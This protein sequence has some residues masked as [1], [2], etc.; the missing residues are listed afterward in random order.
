MSVAKQRVLVPFSGGANSLYSLW[1]TLRQNVTPELLYVTNLFP[2]N[3]SPVERASV[4]QFT[5]HMLDYW[6]NHLWTKRDQ[7]YQWNLREVEIP[8]DELAALHSDVQRVAYLAGLC[9]RTAREAGCQTV[10]WNSLATPTAVEVDTDVLAART[11]IQFV[12]PGIPMG[13]TW[14]AECLD[15]LFTWYCDTLNAQEEQED[16]DDD[17]DTDNLTPA[18][19][20]E[21]GFE[22]WR[23]LWCCRQPKHLQKALADESL[24]NLCRTCGRCKAVRQFIETHVDD[25]S[26]DKM[27]E[28]DEADDREIS[29]KRPRHQ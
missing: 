13:K 18:G 5:R 21:R 9:V 29:V 8:A 14:P 4:Q 10:V 11:G 17:M 16:H 28:V 12:L 1:W 7:R 15:K 26:P 24:P 23:H 20:F 22:L 25:Y 2:H 3:G 6:G 27:Y 19:H